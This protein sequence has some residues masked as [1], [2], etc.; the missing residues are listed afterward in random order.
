MTC[1]DPQLQLAWYLVDVVA[2]LLSATEGILDSQGMM[3][4]NNTMERIFALENIT[5][6]PNL[7]I[8]MR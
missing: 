5:V 7:V 1:N 8:M 3:V 6:N 2:M 4:Y